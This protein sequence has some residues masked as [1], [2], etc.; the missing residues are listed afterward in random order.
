[1]SD[2]KAR[3]QH[4]FPLRMP[5]SLRAAAERLA[6]ADG[7]SVNQFVALAV[8]E[9]VGTLNGAAELERRA[10]RADYARF[11]RIMSRDTPPPDRD[12]DLMPGADG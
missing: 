7:V 10:R 8:A 4:A 5:E 1:M 11:E 3:R 9:K 12:E 6:K 2:A